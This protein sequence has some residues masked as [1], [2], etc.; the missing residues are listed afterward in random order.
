MENGPKVS[1]EATIPWLQRRKL[2]FFQAFWGTIKCLVIHPK[3]FFLC[4]RYESSLKDA[5]LFY[6]INAAIVILLGM[7]G[8]VLE[9]QSLVALINLHELG[10]GPLE[11]PLY[12]LWGLGFLW[13]IIGVFI[14]VAF[15]HL[16]VFILR[17][18]GG[19]SGTFAV[20]AY[21]SWILI[22]EYIPFVGKFISGAWLLILIVKGL[23]HI[24]DFGIVKIILA[25]VVSFFTAACFI[26]LFAVL[27][28]V[29]F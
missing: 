12:L 15:T 23:M 29:L 7:I 17:G 4:L 16:G 1:E 27:L 28:S 11:L 19:F 2:G 9:G 8:A 13:L 21:S 10:I 3:D 26:L 5:Y 18:E 24:H 20:L 14:S 6:V 22:F 25:N